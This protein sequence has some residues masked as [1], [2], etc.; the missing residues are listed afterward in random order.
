MTNVSTVKQ[1]AQ[2]E[3]DSYRN[4]EDRPLSGYLAAMSVYATA[5]AGLGVLARRRG[6]RAPEHISPWDVALFGIATHRVSRTLTKDAVAS[7]VRAPFTTYR[8]LEGPA[9]L[10]TRRPAP[11]HTYGTPSVNC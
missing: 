3:A 11:T 9:E 5:V 2:R 8:G 6:H 4:G 10:W 1:W 7:P